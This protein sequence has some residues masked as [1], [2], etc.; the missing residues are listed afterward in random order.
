MR[1]SKLEREI[2][3]TEADGWRPG[4]TQWKF[5][6]EMPYMNNCAGWMVSMWP[7]AQCSRLGGPGDLEGLAV[8]VEAVEPDFE[9]GY[10]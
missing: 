6:N 5:K 3:R 1:D 8:L 9:H 2:A 10:A 7:T 4:Q